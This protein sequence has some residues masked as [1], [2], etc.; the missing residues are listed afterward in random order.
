VFCFQS[1]F[2]IFLLISPYFWLKKGLFSG[3]FKKLSTIC[4]VALFCSLSRS[5]P[6]FPPSRPASFR[7]FFYPLHISVSAGWAGLLLGVF[8]VLVWAFFGFF[9]WVLSVF[10]AFCGFGFGLGAVRFGGA[11][12]LLFGRSAGR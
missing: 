12:R 2:C 11:F 4:G 3:F 8:L 9:E 1:V 6:A 10:F 5:A 7:S